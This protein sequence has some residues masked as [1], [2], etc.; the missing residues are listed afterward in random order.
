[1]RQGYVPRARDYSR[2]VRS[3][4]QPRVPR[5]TIR[6]SPARARRA[7]SPVPGSAPHWQA[8]PQVHAPRQIR[9]PVNFEA[10]MQ[11]RAARLAARQQA[12]YARFA[13]N[14]MAHEGTV[15]I[16]HPTWQHKGLIR[17]N[18][19]YYDTHLKMQIIGTTPY[20]HVVV[21]KPQHDVLTD[22]AKGVYHSGSRFIKNALEANPQQAAFLGNAADRRKQQIAARNTLISAIPAIGKPL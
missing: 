13:A 21:E 15:V 14:Q 8:P 11:A 22:F 20:T 12:S 6:P 5:T 17:Q 9:G 1:M 19:V 10:A 3:Q 16:R 7:L 18:G 2:P 4:R